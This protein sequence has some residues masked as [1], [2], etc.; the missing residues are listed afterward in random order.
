MN[1]ISHINGHLSD[2]VH[3]NQG[4]FFKFLK[5]LHWQGSPALIRIKWKLSSVSVCFKDFQRRPKWL[6]FA[7]PWQPSKLEPRLLKLGVKV[8]GKNLTKLFLFHFVNACSLKGHCA[9]HILQAIT[10]N[11]M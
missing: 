8:S 7:N 9:S 3:G 1:Y 11:Q 2:P 6:G 10:V 5:Q 4:P